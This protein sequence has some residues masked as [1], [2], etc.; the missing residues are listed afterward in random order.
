MGTNARL[1]WVLAGFFFLADAIYIVWSLL[2]STSPAAQTAP[3][4][5]WV[6]TVA[7]GLTGALS[8]LIAFYL[9][10]IHKAQGGELPEDRLDANIDDG[11]AEQGFFSPWSWW[12][13]VLA[14]SAALT[15]L[16]LAIGPWIA[17]IGVAI[18]LISIVG[19]IFEYYRGYFAR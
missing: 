2:V 5:E 19:W 15:F 11:D 1:F 9:G 4:I 18:F 8:A 3:T 13:I 6:G 7:I 17:F 12:P 14:T 16:G 10:R